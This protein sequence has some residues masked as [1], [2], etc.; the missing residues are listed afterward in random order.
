M[1][2]STL[3]MVK[4]RPY[5]LYNR[6]K[7]K[8]LQYFCYLAPISVISWSSPTFSDQMCNSKQMKMLMK[9]MKPPLELFLMRQLDVTCLF[10]CNKAL[11]YFHVEKLIFTEV[12]TTT[13]VYQ[14]YLNTV[15]YQWNE[16]TLYPF[17]QSC[18]NKILAK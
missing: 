16:H 15:T 3:R 5:I 14:K 9:N 18:E 10:I 13:A 4:Y 17:N 7:N 11:L 1:H 2:F 6:W 8:S 12:Y